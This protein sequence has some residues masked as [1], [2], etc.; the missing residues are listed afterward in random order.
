[1]S[2]PSTETFDLRVMTYNIHKGFNA[3]NTR[4]V[5]HSMRK[6][7][8]QTEADL[9]FLQEIQGQHADRER[10]IDEWPD[11]PQLQFLAGGIWPHQAYGK[12]AIYNAGHHGNAI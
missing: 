3:G 8:V 10:F 5:L 12:N 7:L 11:I 4:F 6:A 2:E 9:I 1:M